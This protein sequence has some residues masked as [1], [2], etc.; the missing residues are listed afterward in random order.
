MHQCSP[1]I[2]IVEFHWLNCAW[3][4]HFTI[5]RKYLFWNKTFYKIKRKELCSSLSALFSCLASVM[6][7]RP[8][9]IWQLTD[10]VGCI[11]TQGEQ[12]SCC[13]GKGN[14][15]LSWCTSVKGCTSKVCP[16]VSQFWKNQESKYEACGKQGTIRKI[17]SALWRTLRIYN[18]EIEQRPQ[19]FLKPVLRHCLSQSFYD[20]MKCYDQKQ[21]RENIYWLCLHITVHH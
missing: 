4:Q 5:T 6:N 7:T 11:G 19:F 21:V 13:N 8:V 18:R 16:R 2:T 17:D 3:F 20:V 1:T 14:I 15:G 12:V 10:G 9:G